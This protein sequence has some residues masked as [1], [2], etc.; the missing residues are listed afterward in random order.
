[1]CPNMADLTT[2]TTPPAD[3]R[4][5]PHALLSGGGSGGHVFPGLAVATELQRRGWGVSWAGARRGMERGLVTRRGL[6]FHPLPAKPLVGRGPLGKV[7]ALLTLA[8]SA[9]SARN[10]VR[11]V[12]AKVVL[13]TGGYVSAPAV[14][15]GR[16]AGVPVVLLEPN[17]EPG[18]ANRAL[19]R[20]AR[21]ALVTDGGAPG[22]KCPTRA[23]GVPIREGFFDIADDLPYGPPL[24]LLVLGG[25]QG[26]RQIN[27]LLPRA[28]AE[29][30][31]A[32]GPLV[33]RHQA[34]KAHLDATVEAYQ[35]VGIPAVAV[36]GGGFRPGGPTVQAEVMPFLHDMPGAMAESHLILSRAGAITLA[37]ICAAGRPSLLVPLS[38]AGGHQVSNAHRQAEAGAAAVLDAAAGVGE[39]R[40]ML[41]G[42]LGD[43]DRL[44]AMAGAARALGRSGAASDIADRVV[45]WGLGSKAGGTP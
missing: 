17:A 18:V 27:D 13:G 6:D 41:A 4:A 29:L 7:A 5:A 26:A 21:E 10:V 38:I 43:R 3:R 33:V 28:L 34:G 42:L 24:R 36:E 12:G 37:E 25:S 9:W 22:L 15:G 20:F 44:D 1:M 8:R 23:T 16:L 19:S 2:H 35:S 11:R 45:F 39:L 31:D 14:I 40:S 30:G 32:L